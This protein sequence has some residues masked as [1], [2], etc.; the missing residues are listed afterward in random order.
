VEEG[1]LARAYREA[2][3]NAIWEGSGNVMALDVQRA[4]QR[5]PQALGSVLDTVLDLSGGDG[6]IEAAADALH[7]LGSE[8]A[9]EAAARTL[10]ERLAL[11]V[12]ASLLKA[13]APVEVSDSFIATRLEGR[14]RVTYGQLPEDTPVRAIL[15]RAFPD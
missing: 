6:R 7:A 11:L 4:L 14:W 10:T 2:P 13:H 15:D 5:R 8:H 3:V 1:L 9:N 12:A